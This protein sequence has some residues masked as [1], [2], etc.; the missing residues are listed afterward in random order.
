MTQD[1]MDMPPQEDEDESPDAVPV[2]RC[3]GAA[4]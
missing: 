4:S 2:P 1:V 3:A